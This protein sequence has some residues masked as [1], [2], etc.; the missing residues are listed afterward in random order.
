MPRLALF[1]MMMGFALLA[2][3]GAGGSF[4]AHEMTGAF[5]RDKALLD[6]WRLT[7]LRSAH[8]H[9]NLF[10]MILVLYGLTMPYARS[11]LRKRQCETIGLVAG[12]IA[13]GPGMM[14]R[15]ALGPTESLDGG[16]IFVG[17]LLTLSLAALVSH[18]FSLAEQCFRRKLN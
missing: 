15:A 18:S 10:G 6:T 4:I 9:T 2:I 17:T 5:L 7:L 16:E 8:G 13:M 1:C 12:A 14:L 3:A 11:S